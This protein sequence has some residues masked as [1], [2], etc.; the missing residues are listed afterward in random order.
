[1]NPLHNPYY[2]PLCKM[3]EVYGKGTVERLK[4]SGGPWEFFSRGDKCWKHIDFAPE[5]VPQNAYRLAP[6]RPMTVP[7]HVIKEG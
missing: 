5:W 4:A 3:D 1:M 6:A 7:W 2:T